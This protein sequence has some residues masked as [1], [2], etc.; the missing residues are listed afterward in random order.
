MKIKI[1]I[2]V[3]SKF[4]YKTIEEPKPEYIPLRLA[5]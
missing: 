1:K 4:F 2:K 3:K 5:S